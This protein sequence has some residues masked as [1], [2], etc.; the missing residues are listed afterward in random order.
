MHCQYIAIN[1]NTGRIICATGNL[2]SLQTVGDLRGYISKS[3][4]NMSYT[5]IKW[6]CIENEKMYHDWLTVFR[7]LERKSV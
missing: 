6:P 2:D 5:I 1:N 3:H 4:I 7:V